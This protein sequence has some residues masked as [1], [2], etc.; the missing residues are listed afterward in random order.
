MKP[1]PELASLATPLKIPG[2]G[3]PTGHVARRRALSSNATTRLEL[4]VSSHYCSPE[5]ATEPAVSA[6]TT[7]TTFRGTGNC[8]AHE[9]YGF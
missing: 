5:A 7:T 3:T 8:N 2:A 4:V 6:E 9:S 1:E